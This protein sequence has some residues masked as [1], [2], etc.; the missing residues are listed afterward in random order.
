M[1]GL[2]LEVSQMKSLTGKTRTVE[3]E[4]IG[5]LKGL[6]ETIDP[7]LTCENCSTSPAY[8]VEVEAVPWILCP[9]CQRI[10]ETDEI[11]A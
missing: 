8:E 11:K 4:I 3:V 7:E 1:A 10:L 2:P 6:P 9:E 5:G